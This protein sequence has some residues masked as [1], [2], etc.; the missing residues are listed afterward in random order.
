MGKN[1]DGNVM[2]YNYYTSGCSPI[3]NWHGKIF[4]EEESRSDLNKNM[5][6]KT[7]LLQHTNQINDAQGLD[8]KSDRV[9]CFAPFQKCFGVFICHLFCKRFSLLIGALSFIV[10]AFRISPGGSAVYVVV[11]SVYNISF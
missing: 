1:S 2:F 7:P 6:E 5:S 3:V 4:K 10:Y 11:L 9:R 8:I